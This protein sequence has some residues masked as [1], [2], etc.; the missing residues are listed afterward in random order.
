M[1]WRALL[2]SL[3]PGRGREA[4][5]EQLD[6]MLEALLGADGL[7]GRPG[8]T[9]QELAAATC[10][11]VTR[12]LAFDECWLQPVSA[13]STQVARWAAADRGAWTTNPTTSDVRGR[14]SGLGA[15]GGVPVLQGKELAGTLM[16]WSARPRAWS[17]RD[18]R[19]LR[20]AAHH[21][22]VA[23]L[24]TAPTQLSD[25][26]R[27]AQE[28]E[29]L[30]SELITTLNHELRTPLTT[31]LGGL[32]LLADG[33]LGELGPDQQR[34]VE[35]LERSVERLQE[36][37]Q[38]VTRLSADPVDPRR[39]DPPE[40]L[41]S[42]DPF[43]VAEA[44]LDDLALR[45]RDLEVVV[46]RPG[47]SVLV[48][49]PEPEVRELLDRV[50][51]NA[52]KFTPDGGRVEVRPGLVHD[53]AV[54]LVVTDTGVG[55]SHRDQLGL[56]TEFFRSTRA[57]RDEKQGSGLG[58]VAARRLVEA[59]GGFLTLTTTEG[60]GTDVCVTLPRSGGP[61]AGPGGRPRG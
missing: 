48:E 59:W 14:R 23:F 29:S 2:D 31:L 41:P 22:G 9:H 44:C 11:L 4:D 16:V 38:N 50:L 28:L 58:L 49:V 37:A 42:T 3:G 10:E 17:S 12:V 51:S 19:V 46:R 45:G 35:R 20:D 21:L 18:R 6:T 47:E 25:R 13:F 39:W 34:L 61:A 56:G 33:A 36:L 27:A 43:A 53:R 26:D 57:R 24:L 7:T 60:V 15:I 40:T 8:I 54:E 55:I 1:P 30:R 32:D 5:G 52:V